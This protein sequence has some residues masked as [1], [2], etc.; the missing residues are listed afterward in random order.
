[1]R[2][3]TKSLFSFSWAMSLFG[4]QQTLNL[5]SSSKATEAFDHVTKATK[6]E[7]GDTMRA[8]FRAGDDLQRRM[9]DLTFGLFTGQAFN[10]NQWVRAAS[11]VMDQSAEAMGQGMRATTAG[12]QQAASG[13][14]ATP[15]G[16]QSRASGSPGSCA[17][18]SW[19]PASAQ[20]SRK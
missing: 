3:F 17:S 18:Q 7:M 6:E 4:V 5:L 16:S 10:P 11:D 19:E 14:G 13:W 20:R 1:M 9:V 12:A 8:T 2:D 15:N